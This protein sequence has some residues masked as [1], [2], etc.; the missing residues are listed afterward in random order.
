MGY[1]AYP[2]DRIILRKAHPMTST[3]TFCR[4]LSSI[5]ACAMLVVLASCMTKRT[6]LPEELVGQA[7]V[8][9][10]ETLPIRIW[11]DASTAELSFAQYHN[12]PTLK[13]LKDPDTGFSHQDY[14]VLSGGGAKGAYGA[15]LLNGW[16][17]TGTR[18][19]FT[20]VTGVSTGAIIAPFAFLGPAYDHLL[21][22]FYTEHS[23]K[24]LLRIN[25][26]G[27]VI[28]G[29]SAADSGPLEKLIE[30]YITP[31]LLQ[32]IASEYAQGRY[33]LV[34]TTNLDAQRPVTWNMGEIARIGGVEG[35]A[36]FRKVILA[37][38]SIPAA[39][40]PVLINVDADGVSGDE[41]HV[42][43]GTTDNAIL[44]PVHFQINKQ[45][46]FS[47]K[48]SRRRLFIIINSSLTPEPENA[49]T[50]TLHIAMR[51]LNT[52]LK[53]QTSGDALMLYDYA[54]A[55]NIE[56]NL[57]QIPD[58]FATKPKELFDPAYMRAL[59]NLGVQQA[60]SQTVWSKAP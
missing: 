29:S 5:L 48:A 12:T 59:Y 6:P 17:Q 46:A 11:G 28:A 38:I 13:V 53:Q 23:T 32:E 50:G 22:E 57:T 35:L 42:D 49:K 40:P 14:L 58:S 45:V 36:L 44:L 24:D 18:P 4:R 7:R 41:L 10:F 39:F 8:S 30:K 37:S 26:L 43:G 19:E 27:G 9:G 47:G 1:A 56:Y 52:L 51:S 54:R 16:S 55:N 34:G 60:K 15:G 33:L 20:I 21:R 3:T 31:R 25:G 2:A